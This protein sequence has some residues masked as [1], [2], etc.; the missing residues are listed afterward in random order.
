MHWL[1]AYGQESLDVPENISLTPVLLFCLRM[2]RRLY[3]INPILC[4]FVIVIPVSIAG[5]ALRTLVIDVPE[6]TRHCAS[7]TPSSWCELRALAINPRFYIAS[8]VAGLIAL[9]RASVN[10]SALSIAIGVLGLFSFNPY[11]SIANPDWSIAGLILGL[12]A[13]MRSEEK[14]STENDRRTPIHEPE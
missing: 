9:R 2:L 12:L 5:I 13:F 3:K 14:I 8:L 1:S 10:W 4:L 6:I 7:S 11:W